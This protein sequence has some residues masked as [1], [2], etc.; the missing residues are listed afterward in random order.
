MN[1]LV[2]TQSQKACLVKNIKDIEYNAECQSAVLFLHIPT[3]A[4]E[5]VS[6]VFTDVEKIEPIFEKEGTHDETQ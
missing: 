3:G 1:Y 5:R 6:Y 4:R 2:K